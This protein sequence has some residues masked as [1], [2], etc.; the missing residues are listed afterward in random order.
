VTR[1][2]RVRVLG[3]DVRVAVQ[4]GA[5][6]SMTTSGALPMADT[7]GAYVFDN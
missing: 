5:V 3:H 4:A 7:P 6:S 1:F 2:L